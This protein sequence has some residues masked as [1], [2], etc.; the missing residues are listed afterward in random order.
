MLQITCPWCGQRD[1]IEFRCG[2]PS[3][4]HRPEPYDQISDDVWAEYL[5]NRTNPKG[6][7]HERWV[8]SGGCRRWFNL[9]RD[10]VSHEIGKAYEMS[11]P[12]PTGEGEQRS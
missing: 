6:A 7:H 11:E 5:F 1:Q 9:V 2:G 3:H 4:I 8:H 10:T 12:A